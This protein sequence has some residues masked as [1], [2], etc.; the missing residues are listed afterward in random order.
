MLAGLRRRL[1]EYYSRCV[2]TAST[3]AIRRAASLAC[4]VPL[5]LW[6]GHVGLRG[7]TPAL[8]P[9]TL[10]EQ[11]LRV[12]VDGIGSADLR[13]RFDA[14][15]EERQRVVD[16]ATAALRLLISWFGPPA[17]RE[18]KIVGTQWSSASAQRAIV[19]DAD[20]IVVQRWLSPRSDFVLERQVIAALARAHW[21]SIRHSDASWRWFEDGLARYSAARVINEVL[22]PRFVPHRQ[23]LRLFGGYVPYPLRALS[24]SRGRRD[25][26]PPLQWYPEF[27]PASASEAPSSIQSSDPAQ[28]AAAGLLM[29][30]RLIGW[31]AIQQ[32]LAAFA[33]RYQSREPT[34][35]DLAVV[36]NEQRGVDS[37]EL[38]IEGLTLRVPVD[39]RVDGLTTML[40]EDGRFDTRVRLGRTAGTLPIR[41]PLAVRF[42][43]GDEVRTSWD[44]DAAKSELAFESTSPA[45]SALVDPDVMLVVDTN[46][47]NNSRV[48][49]A[50]PLPAGVRSGLRWFIWLQNWMLT[51]ASLL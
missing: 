24:W 23:V 28:R 45:V 40:Q 38:V 51:C 49:Q 11:S 1:A 47:Q 26:R 48:L 10:D 19:D 36:L 32:A 31:S 5:A 39:Y 44:G 4:A 35:R 37:T 6:L 15:F 50:T 46:R 8:N 21:R 22:D 9:S 16:A 33:Q 7:Q 43:S 20:G 14:G 17:Q 3:R 30:E 41:V 12:V 42:A 29:L 18:L 2:A 13:I 27:E 25:A 34:P